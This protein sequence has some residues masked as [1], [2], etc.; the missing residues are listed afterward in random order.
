M[1]A[2]SDQPQVENLIRRAHP[3]ATANGSDSN[4]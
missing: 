2:E 3:H 1:I 4:E